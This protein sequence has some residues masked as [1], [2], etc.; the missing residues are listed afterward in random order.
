MKMV[1]PRDNC[2]RCCIC[3]TVMR[4]KSLY[5]HLQ[6]VHMFT[7]DQVEDVKRDVAREAGDYKNVWRV[8]CPECGEKFPDHHS[9]A[10]HCDEHHQDVGACGQPQDYKVVTK[11][12]DTYVEFERW[13]SEECERTCSSLSR[14][15]FSSA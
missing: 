10:K 13:F 15:S 8:F 14:K 5:R 12:F 3:R 6:S 9:L 11:T 4:R 7:K 2:W 1:S